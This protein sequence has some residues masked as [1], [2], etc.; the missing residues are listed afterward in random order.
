MNITL[1]GYRGTGKSTVARWIAGR[2]GWNW[3]DADECV[4]KLAGC[5]IREVFER[6]GESGFRDRES[7][8]IRDLLTQDRVVIAAGGG[9]ILRPENR[10]AIKRSTMAVWLT[11]S[12][13][14]I[15]KRIASDASTAERRPALTDVGGVKEI[16]RLLEL[17]EPLYRECAGLIID[18]D[19]CSPEQVADVIVRAFKAMSQSTTME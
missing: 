8:V 3:I 7:T 17:R 16:R 4:E 18:T 11:A 14:L 6:E 10:L 19:Q 15:A 1:I 12:V 9:S 5:S 13:E 2:L